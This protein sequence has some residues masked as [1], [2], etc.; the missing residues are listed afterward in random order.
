[1]GMYVYIFI[2]IK[3]SFSVISLMNTLTAHDI[4]GCLNSV[5]PIQNQA[6]FPSFMGSTE[7]R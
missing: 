1:M 6:T 7:W 4:M 3:C 2:Q 5:L